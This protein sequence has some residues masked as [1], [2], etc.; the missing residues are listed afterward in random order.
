MQK[1]PI[2]L[3]Q[4]GGADIP[5][6]EDVPSTIKLIGRGLDISCF[7]QLAH[8]IELSKEQFATLLR[9]PRT[10]MS[11]RKKTGLFGKD[12]SERL[13][14]FVRVFQKA[15][16]LFD[17]D[18][19]GARRWLKTPDELFEGRTPLEYA[20]TEPGALFVLNVIGRLEHGV[21]S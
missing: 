7:D 16:E 4:S 2:C 18:E 19:A 21:F 17:G 14:R 20:E 6:I 8:R 13:I 3:F 15:V 11:R 5:P 10:T 9:I 12:E 1:Q